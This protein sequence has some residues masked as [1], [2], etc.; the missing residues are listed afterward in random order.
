M[1]DKALPTNK[2]LKFENF[3]DAANALD[4]LN[5]LHVIGSQ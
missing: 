2:I 1:I 4:Y 3:E 5:D